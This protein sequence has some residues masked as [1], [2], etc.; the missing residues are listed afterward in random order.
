MAKTVRTA[1]A[2]PM[3]LA[4]L[5]VH[6]D[7]WIETSLYSNSLLGSITSFLHAASPGGSDIVCVAS[8]PQPTDIGYIW[9]LS[10]DRTLRLWTPAGGCVSQTT[11]PAVAAGRSVTPAGITVPKSSV[12]LHP[13]PQQPSQ[14]ARQ[15]SASL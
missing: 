15:L 12:L 6:T 14:L 10:R 9:T 4:K 5:H 1:A 8:H 7:D 2:L 3:E 11:L 13:H